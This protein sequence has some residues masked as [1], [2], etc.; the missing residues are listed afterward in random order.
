MEGTRINV[1]V[2][3]KGKVVGI[4][5]VEQIIGNLEEALRAN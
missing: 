3:E 5:P 4:E 2:I 1:Y